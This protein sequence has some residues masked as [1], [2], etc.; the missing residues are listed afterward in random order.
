MSDLFG[1][2]TD[3]AGVMLIDRR[4]QHSRRF[5]GAHSKNIVRCADLPD[6]IIMGQAN[7]CD[8]AEIIGL[9]AEQAGVFE[10][11]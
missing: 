4:Q 1:F 11:G 2:V 10:Q 5:D 8:A 9:N 6:P 7:R 3:T